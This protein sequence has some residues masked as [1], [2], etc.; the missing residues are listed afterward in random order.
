MP[1][2]KRVAVRQGPK[3]QFSI[4]MDPALKAKLEEIAALRGISL[5]TLI[6][7]MTR[8]E[9]ARITPETWE[10]LQRIRRVLTGEIT[11]PKALSQPHG[12]QDKRRR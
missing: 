2:N 1:Y 3:P 5:S 4:T 11:S 9:L 7:E 10:E 8:K 6:E 12:D